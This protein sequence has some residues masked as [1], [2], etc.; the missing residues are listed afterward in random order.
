LHRKEAGE[1]AEKAKKTTK[2]KEGRTGE[3]LYDE[4]TS[5]DGKKVE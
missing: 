4:K 5:F 3:Y 1:V 2:K